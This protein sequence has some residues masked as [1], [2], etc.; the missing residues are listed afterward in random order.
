MKRYMAACAMLLT[1]LLILCPHVSGTTG[2]VRDLSRKVLR[3]EEGRWFGRAAVE[4]APD[5]TWVLAYREGGIHYVNDG[6]LHIAFSDDEGDTWSEEDRGLD[7]GSIARF[8]AHPPGAGPDQPTGPGEPWLY[9]APDGT[10][11][12]HCWKVDYGERS[13]NGGTWQISSSDGGRTWTDWQRVDFRGIKKDKDVFATDDHFVIEGTIYA[14]A[15]RYRDGKWKNILI[16]SEDNGSTWSKVSDISSYAKNTSEVGVD[17]MDGGRIL[18]V[19]NTKNRRRVYRTW[20]RDRGAEWQP[21]EDIHGQ[22]AIWDRCRIWTRAHVKGQEQWWND[23]VILGVGDEAVNRGQS[24][25]RRNSLWISTDAG[26]TWSKP[27]ALDEQTQ[28]AGYGD[29]M[30]DHAD[31]KYVFISYHGAMKEAALVQ[32]EFRLSGDLE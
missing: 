1:F 8:P 14:G 19:L 3:A 26:K 21:L 23:D 17:L 9:R 2:P 31:D 7:G 12:L 13:R 29:L 10:L 18:A 20:G 32:Y 16:R 27:I 24:T 22:T 28:D 4:E 11:V 30:Y 5:G 6:V 25:P 15:R